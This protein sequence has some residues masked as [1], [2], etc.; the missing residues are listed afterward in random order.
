MPLKKM[1]VETP[2]MTS[3]RTI[4][5]KLIVWMYALPRNLYQLM[6]IAA[7]VPRIVATSEDVNAMNKLLNN[8]VQSGVESKKSFLYQM[9][10]KPVNVESFALL[11]E[12]KMITK[13]GTNRKSR[14][15]TS[16]VFE[17]LNC[18]LRFFHERFAWRIGSEAGFAFVVKSIGFFILCLHQLMKN[19]LLL[20]WHVQ[21]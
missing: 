7:S 21:D 5:R 13:S 14:V 3:G 2:M 12:K 20:Q 8:A 9:K 19:L 10:E 4:G 17:R 18:G 11:K 1:S 6:P 16:T 15:N